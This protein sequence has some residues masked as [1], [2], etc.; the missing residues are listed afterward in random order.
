MSNDQIFQISH[1]KLGTFRRCKQQYHWKYI[2]KY[3]PKSSEG[4][5]RGSAGHAGLAEW[6]RSYDA[7]KAMDAAWNKWAAEGWSEGE[8]W[9]L[10][11]ETLLRYF[12]WSEQNDTFTIIQSEQKFSFVFA[13]PDV[14]LIGFIDGIVKAEDGRMWLLEN[15]FNKKVSTGGLDIDSQSTMYLLAAKLLNQPAVGVLY[16]IIRVGTKIALKEPVVRKSLYRNPN[17]LDYALQEILQQ[18]RE[19]I[20]YHEEGGEPYRNPTRDCSWD[21]PFYTACLNLL[22]DGIEP[23]QQLELACNLTKKEE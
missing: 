2:N 18:A 22:E 11:E 5:V 20:K 8:A 12:A 10:T 14:K 6:H 3:Y 15:K 1:T 13:E 23:T 19:M 16:N 4:Q 17:G 9:Q 21:C 7:A